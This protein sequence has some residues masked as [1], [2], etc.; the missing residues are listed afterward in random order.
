MIKVMHIITTLGPAGAETMLCRMVSRMDRSRFEN[1]IVSLTGIL[2][3]AE[4]MQAIG[5][6]VRTLGMRTS[7]P[8]PLSVMRLAQWIRNSKPDVI[9]TWMYHANLIGA[10]AARLAGHV[11]VVWGIHH[12]ALDPR[13]DKRR[14]ILVNYACAL[15]SRKFPARII[16]CSQASLRIHEQLSYAAEKMEVIPNGFDLEQVKP[17]PDAR[18]S[19][20]KELG[21]PTDAILIGIAARFHPL[22]DHRNFLWAAARLHEKMPEVHFLLCGLDITWENPQLAGW[23]EAAGIRNRCHLLGVRHDISRLFAAMDIS[24]TASRS[25]A[26]PVVIGEAM[27]C[28]TPC[29]VT[30]VGD[31]ALIVG[32]TGMVVPPGDPAALAEAWRKLIEAGPEIR[33]RLGMAARRRVQQHFALPGIVER[34]QS[35]YSELTAGMEGRI[36]QPSLS[37]CSR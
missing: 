28:G 20:C 27:A 21:I 19:I 29:V 33:E 17:D 8:N 26:F 16:C 3:Q 2:D 5:M 37:H 30:D 7:M 14:T 11:P 4:K 6:R 34:Y 35:I 12:S 23:I 32:E 25:E 36:P 24:T 10:L 15:L 13:I 9:Q 18:A 1:E 31:S 22:K